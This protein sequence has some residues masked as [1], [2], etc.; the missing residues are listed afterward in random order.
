[1]IHCLEMVSFLLVGK[2]TLYNV[3]ETKTL[4]IR[5]CGCFGYVVEMLLRAVLVVA[6]EFDLVV[7][8]VL[9]DAVVCLLSLS[10]LLTRVWTID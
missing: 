2:L 1:M 3:R 10:A 8:S 4:L 5:L 9:Y 7:I 6:A